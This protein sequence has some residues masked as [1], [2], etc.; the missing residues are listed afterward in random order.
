MFFL[1]HILFCNI[2]F[3][4]N[5]NQVEKE[6]I[7]LFK[8]KFQETKELIKSLAESLIQEIELKNNIHLKE[9]LQGTLSRKIFNNTGE[10]LTINILISHINKTTH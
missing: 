1:L 5:L 7:Q 8:E 10:I 4:Q 3:P 9:L 2:S 6:Q